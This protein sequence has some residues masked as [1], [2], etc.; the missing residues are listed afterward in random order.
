[1]NKK[2]LKL[3]N[4]NLLFGIVTWMILSWYGNMDPS[5]ANLLWVIMCIITVQICKTI[6]CDTQHF[7]WSLGK[8]I[9]LWTDVRGRPPNTKRSTSSLRHFPV[10]YEAPEKSRTKAEK[11]ILVPSLSSGQKNGEKKG[12]NG[13]RCIRTVFEL[14]C[15]GR[16]LRF[17]YV[18]VKSLQFHYVRRPGVYEVLYGSVVEIKSDNVFFFFLLN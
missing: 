7:L 14:S 1:M 16:L 6:F 3:P 11:S 4:T 13:V 15:P 18:T 17:L 5:P 9:C 2:R 12:R 8:E 10:F